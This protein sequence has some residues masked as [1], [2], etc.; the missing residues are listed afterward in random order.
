MFLFGYLLA[1]AQSRS[2]RKLLPIIEKSFDNPWVAKVELNVR[3]WPG[4]ETQLHRLWRLFKSGA[5]SD[6]MHWDAPITVSIFRKRR[7]NDR[8]ALCMSLYI[9]SGILYIAQLQGVPGTDPPKELRA[10]PKLFIDACKKFACQ[11]G[12]REVRVPKANTLTSFRNPYGRAITEEL[13][14]VVPRIRRN[15][16]LLYDK[17]ALELGLLPE[18]DW[19]KWQN[20]NA[21]SDQLTVMQHAARIAA[22]LGLIAATTVI[23]FQVRAAGAESQ[24]LVYVYLMPLI[25]IAALYTER[26]AILCAGVAILCADY[27]L[28]DPIF[29]FYTAEWADLILFAAVAALAI[30][31]T[32]NLL[33]PRDRGTASLY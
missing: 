24:W 13:K 4:G 16:E 21:Q 32:G 31:S 23:L 8:Q 27:F 1:Q 11:Q 5:R 6:F 9:Q 20:A 30:K 7:G 17:N 2:I 19:F 26:A 3:F 33:P 15:M 29:S 18:G 14:K 22:A 10:W 28:Q 25:V 12:L